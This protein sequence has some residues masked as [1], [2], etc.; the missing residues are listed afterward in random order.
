MSGN[1]VDNLPLVSRLRSLSPVLGFSATSRGL[2]ILVP[3][4]Y[5]YRRLFPNTSEFHHFIMFHGVNR[6]T[7][8][9]N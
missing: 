8:R 2:C 3:P 4:F 5:K 9:N 7:T 1:E 6:P